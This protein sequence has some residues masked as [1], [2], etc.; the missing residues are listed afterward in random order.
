VL[1]DEP[2]AGMS[3]AETD[4]FAA[5]VEELPAALSVVIVEHDLDIAFRL[6]RDVTVLAAG[7]VIAS[8]PPDAI[9]ADEQV[10]RAYLGTSST[11]ALF[12]EAP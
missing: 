9:R 4:R 8:G 6:A 1:F 3:V 2:T 5:L 7:R 10:Q 11:E 12:T